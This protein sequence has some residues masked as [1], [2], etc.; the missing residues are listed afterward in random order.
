VPCGLQARPS[1]CIAFSPAEDQTLLLSAAG[2]QILRTARGR[3]PV[4]KSYACRSTVV[5]GWLPLR[6]T[7]ALGPRAIGARVAQ[8]PPPPLR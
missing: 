5:A 3:L 4:V 7:R 6:R 2:P 8:T 1:R